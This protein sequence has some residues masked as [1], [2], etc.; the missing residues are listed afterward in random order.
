MP[1]HR[2][3]QAMPTDDTNRD[4]L[5]HRAALQLND[6]RKLSSLSSTAGEH[7][8]SSPQAQHSAC[9]HVEPVASLLVVALAGLHATATTCVVARIGCG[10]VCVSVSM[11]VSECVHSRCQ[12]TCAMDGGQPTTG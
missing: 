12:C 2:L 1:V 5:E 11:G 4:E 8:C 6:H 7:V 3:R 9:E 10:C